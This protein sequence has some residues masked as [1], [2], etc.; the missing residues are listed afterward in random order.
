MLPMHLKV[1]H[2][3]APLKHYFSGPRVIANSILILGKNS[4]NCHNKENYKTY[5]FCGQKYSFAMVFLPMLCNFMPDRKTSI[6]HH[7]GHIL[8]VLVLAKYLLR[9]AITHLHWNLYL[10]RGSRMA[11]WVLTQNSYYN[12]LQI[13]LVLCGKW[14]IIESL[15]SS[16]V[17]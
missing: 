6:F 17:I 13:M 11:K 5:P 4:W 8:N 1:R 7:S 9:D 2:A 10:G 15:W 16:D 12:L 14:L 3:Y